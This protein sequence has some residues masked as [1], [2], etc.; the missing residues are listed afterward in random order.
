M[1]LQAIASFNANACEWTVLPVQ[2]LAARPNADP[3]ACRVVEVSMIYSVKTTLVY[4]DLP[5]HHILGLYAS[6]TWD[7]CHG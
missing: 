7:H 4:N 1:I 3:L 6:P 5:A 2:E